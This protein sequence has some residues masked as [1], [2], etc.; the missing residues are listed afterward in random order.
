MKAGVAEA[1]AVPRQPCHP[2]SIEA[3]I[4]R[5]NP[6]G[7]WPYSRGG[8]W[9]E[10][11]V[12]AIMALLSAGET[13]SAQRGIAWLASIARRDGGWPPRA[14]VDMSTWVTALVALL[15]PRNIG[16]APHGRAIRWLLDTTG[17]ESTFAFRLRE[18][19]LGNT[20]SGIDAKFPGWPWVPS[21]AGW[22]VPTSVAILALD[23][24][25]RRQPSP[26][27]LHRI[28]AGRYFLLGRTCDEGGW[29]YGSSHPL[30][31]PSRPYPETTGIA[32][33]ALRG[34]RSSRVRHALAAAE[35]F[36]A[37][38]RSA[39]ALNWLRFGLRVHG[40]LPAGYC[41]PAGVEFRTVPETSLDL[42]MTAAERGRDLFWG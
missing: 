11:T 24:E 27:I 26:E 18:W 19:L 17:E 7:G 36:L 28:E 13:V 1:G 29:N 5:Q 14:G 25:Q 8:S 2:M 33:A 41:A 38:C 6:D 32:L 9:T 35:G 16:A 23:Q 21:N 20:T 42:V 15:G 31:Y 3:L 40:R 12:Y 4:G 22:V 37:E 39:D 30:G 10:P 34:N